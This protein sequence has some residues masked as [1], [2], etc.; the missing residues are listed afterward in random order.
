M[1]EARILMTKNHI[2][3]PLPWDCLAEPQTRF[4]RARGE[5]PQLARVLLDRQSAKILAVEKQQVEGDGGVIGR[6]I[7]AVAGGPTTASSTDAIDGCR[8]AAMSVLARTA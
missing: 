6:N 8:A 3:G 5:T 7:K 4:R 2:S 1:R